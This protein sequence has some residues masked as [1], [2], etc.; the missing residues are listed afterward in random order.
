MLITQVVVNNMWQQKIITNLL[1]S[2]VSLDTPLLLACSGGPDSMA[3]L[4]ILVTYHFQPIVCHMNYHHRDS[5][6]RDQNYVT[7]YCK[8]HEL[9]CYVKDYQPQGHDNFQEDARLARYQFFKEIYE[10]HHAK[11]LIVAHQKDDV[12]ETYLLQKKR[13]NQVDYYG[14]ASFT[15][16]YDMNVYRPALHVRKQE[17]LQYC[18]DQHLDYGIDESNLQDEY[19]RNIIR[20]HQLSQYSEQQIEQLMQEINNKN[21]ENQFNKEYIQSFIHDNYFILSND[22]TNNTLNG[23]I[24]RMFLKQ[25]H[26]DK[27][28]G[29]KDEYYQDIIKRLKNKNHMYLD[30]YLIEGNNQCYYLYPIRIYRPLTFNKLEYGEYDGFRLQRQGNKRQG[31]TLLPQDFPITIRS[32]SQFDSIELSF[33]HKKINRYFIDHKISHYQRNNTLVIENK[34]HQVIFVSGIGADVTHYSDSNN[35]FMVK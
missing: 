25:N 4:D 7:D 3:L 18:I 26:L 28:C 30:H 12:L 35:V 17:L 2:G 14:I 31:L 29:Y 23:L 5:A 33:G 6:N 27:Y 34:D 9:T 13:H 8:N 19:Q 32:V 11:G 21:K 10:K 22:D 20:H 16:L 1:N 24:L 15:T